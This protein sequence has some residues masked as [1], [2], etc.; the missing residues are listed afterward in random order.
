[1]AWDKGLG[2]DKDAG[3]QDI[4]VTKRTNSPGS[5]AGWAAWGIGMLFRLARWVIIAIG[6]FA[7][8]NSL[9]T[10]TLAPAVWL[11]TAGLPWLALTAVAMVCGGYGA[12]FGGPPKPSTPW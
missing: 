4:S 10:A 11:W 2:V 7:V 6:G 12:W 3:W 8:M 9:V 1:M 5:V